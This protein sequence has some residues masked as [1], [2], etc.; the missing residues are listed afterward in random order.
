MSQNSLGKVNWRWAFS[1]YF[2]FAIRNCSAIER[3]ELGHDGLSSGE[4]RVPVF[5]QLA[6]FDVKRVQHLL[7]IARNRLDVVEGL[8]LT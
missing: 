2:I 4:L 3:Y 6:L 8:R 5:G 1:L 7:S